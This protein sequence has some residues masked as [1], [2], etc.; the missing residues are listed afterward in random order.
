MLSTASVDKRK[1]CKQTFLN[2]L[3]FYPPI[4][5][6]I[7]RC[8]SGGAAEDLSRLPWDEAIHRHIQWVSFFLGKQTSCV[9]Y[10]LSTFLSCTSRLCL[11][12][13]WFHPLWISAFNDGTQKDLLKLIGNLPVQYEGEVCLNTPR[14]WKVDMWWQTLLNHTLYGVIIMYWWQPL[15]S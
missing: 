6:Q 13:K 10:P 15:L 9:F 11:A 14:V 12:E 7:P 2:M 5:V 8:C 3:C 1:L 4:L